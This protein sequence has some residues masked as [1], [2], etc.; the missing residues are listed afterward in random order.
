MKH[1]AKVKRCSTEG[2]KSFAVKGGV[3]MRHGAQTK[4]C[5]VEGCTNYSKRRGV[6]WR[7][8]AYRNPTDESTAFT[9]RFGSDFDKT[10]LTHSNQRTLS[11]SSTQGNVPAEVAVCVVIANNTEHVEV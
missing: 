9:S 5:S 3:C 1:G 6:C 4:R 8:G 2:C 7:H 10:T 11:A